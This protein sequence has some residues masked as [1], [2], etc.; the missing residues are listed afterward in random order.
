M[1]H[2]F[3]CHFASK[4]PQNSKSVPILGPCGMTELPSSKG[5]FSCQGTINSM[6]VFWHP[7]PKHGWITGYGPPFLRERGGVLVFSQGDAGPHHGECCQ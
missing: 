3:K 2:P 4:L 6:G 7:G 1:L 5:L